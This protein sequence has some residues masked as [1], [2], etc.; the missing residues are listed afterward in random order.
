MLTFRKVLFP[1][2]LSPRCVEIAPYVASIAHKFEAE[3]VLLHAF[4]MYE[5]LPYDSILP[6]NVSTAYEDAIREQRTTELGN[7][8]RKAFR[9]ANGN[10]PC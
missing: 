1:V 6:L 5:D 4:V 8:G 10:A 2:D 9:R 3:L 7:L